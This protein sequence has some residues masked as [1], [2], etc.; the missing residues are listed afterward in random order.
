VAIAGSA[1]MV[2]G[3]VGIISFEKSRIGALLLK[4]SN[5]YTPELLHLPLLPE[6]EP[7]PHVELVFI[8]AN[9]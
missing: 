3:H 6:R 8:P 5:A 4:F 9:D 2:L 1:L 7:E